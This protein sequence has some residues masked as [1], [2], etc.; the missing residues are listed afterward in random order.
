MWIADLQMSVGNGHL[1]MH[2]MGSRVTGIYNH[3]WNVPKKLQEEILENQ[4]MSTVHI[5]CRDTLS[6]L[7]LVYKMYVVR[8]QK[9]RP[10]PFY[11]QF[12]L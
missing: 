6:R 2:F 5:Q 8:N 9:H 12:D 11:L 7:L 3:P 10:K 4:K 1:W